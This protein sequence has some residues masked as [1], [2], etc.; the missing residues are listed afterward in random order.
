MTPKTALDLTGLK[1]E[2]PQVWVTAYDFFQAQLAEEA[3]VDA[4]LVGDS[5]GMTMLGYDS[6]LS[7][8]MEDMLYHARVVRRGAPHTVMIVDLPFLSYRTVELAL[9]NA[10][11]LLQET[12][13]EGIK[14]EGGH[15]LAET[16]V[17]LVAEGIP[18]IGHLGLTP[19]SVH[20]MGGYRVQARSREHIEQL[21]DD[22]ESLAQAGISALV[23]E[24]IPDKVGALVTERIQVPTIGIGAGHATDG[25]VLVFHDCLGLSAYTPK[26]VAPFAQGRQVLA[27]GLKAYRSAVLDRTFPDDDHAYHMAHKEWERFI[28]GEAT[29]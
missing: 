9:T 14:I 21:L 1:L 22:A 20:T 27:E 17:S 4:I 26:F 12:Q 5:L 6:T 3:Q 10:G 18:V 11:R 16:V 8:T 2:R 25:Q 7:V 13:A 28:A 29:R 23:L 19:Q 24:G 15:R